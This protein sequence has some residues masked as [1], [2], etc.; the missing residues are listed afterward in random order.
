MAVSE[1]RQQTVVRYTVPCNWIRYDFNAIAADLVEAKAAILALIKTPYQRNWVD[2]L[3]EIQLKREVAGTSRIEGADFTER[4]LDIALKVDATREDLLTRS[5]RQA[6]SAV[7]AYRW[8][9]TLPDDHPL[10]ERLIQEVHRRLVTGC[11]DDHCE[12]WNF[13]REQGLQRLFRSSPA[14]GLRRR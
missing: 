3:Q 6:H 10:N 13:A 12:P 4:E 9:A 1:P 14:S 2:A 11:D 8:I 5:Q 7:Q